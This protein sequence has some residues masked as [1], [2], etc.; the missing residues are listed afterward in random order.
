MRPPIGARWYYRTMVGI[1][2]VLACASC[3]SNMTTVGLRPAP[4]GGLKADLAL[5]SSRDLV[6]VGEMISI[7]PQGSHLDEFDSNLPATLEERSGGGWRTVRYLIYGTKSQGPS[8]LVAKPNVT[9]VFSAR[10]AVP[11]LVRIP[12]IGAGRYRIRLDLV[13]Q[14]LLDR[15]LMERTVTLFT[16]VDVT[17]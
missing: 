17:R 16:Y 4:L 12:Q 13:N 1:V 11:A 14:L 6:R 2:C 10:P 5:R 3:G 15:P 8:D 7:I 9:F